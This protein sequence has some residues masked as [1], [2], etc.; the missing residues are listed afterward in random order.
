MAPIGTC[1]TTCSNFHVQI[2]CG[3]AIETTHITQQN[4]K[5]CLADICSLI[6]GR[7]RWTV[8]RECWYI[9]E[10]IWIIRMLIQ[11]SAHATIAIVEYNAILCGRGPWLYCICLVLY[12]S[13]ILYLWGFTL[14]G[15][16]KVSLGYESPPVLLDR[17]QGTFTRFHSHAQ[18][19]P[20]RY[21][22]KY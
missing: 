14:C 13:D 15:R 4:K 22:G 8:Q 7:L 6:H 21:W 11:S 9:K 16:K 17:S 1:V 5:N 3:N 19:R 12:F 18:R 20:F 2:G 10:L